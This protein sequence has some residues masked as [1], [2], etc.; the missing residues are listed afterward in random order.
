MNDC[1]CP[2]SGGLWRPGKCF[3][4]LNPLIHSPGLATGRPM[5]AADRLV[6]LVRRPSS[7]LLS[8]TDSE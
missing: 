5:P 3:W 2:R 6:E 8:S 1:G 7:G 4:T